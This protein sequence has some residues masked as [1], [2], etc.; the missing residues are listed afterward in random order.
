MKFV[1]VFGW[2]FASFLME[3]GL[4]L[5]RDFAGIW[6]RFSRDSARCDGM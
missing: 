3:L 1:P 4:D 5:C 2:G 6:S